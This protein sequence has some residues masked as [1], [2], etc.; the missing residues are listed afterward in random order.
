[1]KSVFIK[2]PLALALITIVGCTDFL[3]EE[4]P[5]NTTA[6]NYYVT[7]AGYEGLINAVYS[8]VRDVYQPTPYVFCAGTG[9]LP[10]PDSGEQ[11]GGVPV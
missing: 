7:K 10:D 2:I 9:C 5:G 3:E 6:E 1:M 11:S 8:S 4:N